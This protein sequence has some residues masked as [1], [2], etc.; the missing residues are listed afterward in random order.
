M[1]PAMFMLLWL[2][3]VGQ[4][5]WAATYYVRPAG[6]GTCATATTDNDAS[7]VGSIQAGV[8]CVQGA[9]DTVIVHGGTYSSFSTITV[10]PNKAGTSF[11]NPITLKAAP[12]ESVTLQGELD[13]LCAPCYWIIERISIDAGD[14]QEL[15]T[16]SGDFVRWVDGEF[17]NARHSGMQGCGG[18]GCEFIRMKVHHNGTGPNTKC[19]PPNSG[20]QCHGIYI[21]DG[22]GHL[23]DGGEFYNNEAFGIHGHGT[24]SQITIRNIKAHNNG[25]GGIF[26]DGTGP[27]T[28]YNNVLYNDAGGMNI[29]A[30]AN[31]YSNTAYGNANDGFLL[32]KTGNTIRNNIAYN[33]GANFSTQGGNTFSNNLCNATGGE[34]TLAGN[35]GFVNAPGGDFHLTAGS[36]AID[37]GFTLGAPYNVDADGV[38]RPQGAAYDIGAYEF[39]AAPPPQPDP[40][41]LVGWWKANGDA[42]DSS[43][44]GRHAV[45]TGGATAT[46][47][48]LVNDGGSSFTL[49]GVNAEITVTSTGIGNTTLRPSNLG[50]SLWMQASS[51]PGG[52][53]RAVVM[54]T[55]AVGFG[56]AV[57]WGADGLA[58]FW[59]NN[60]STAAMATGTVLNNAIHHLAASYD[61]AVMRLWVDN[62]QVASFA[63]T[64]VIGYS[65]SETLYIGGSAGVRCSGLIDQVRIYDTPLT[66]TAVAN[67]FAEGPAVPQSSFSVTH[68][69][70]AR[71]NLAEGNWLTATDASTS[72]FL[73]MPVGW[74][75]AIHYVGAP[76]TPASECFPLFCRVFHAGAWGA[77]TQV[78][79]T[80]GALGIRYHSDTAVAQGAATTALLPLD[81]FTPIAGAFLA[82]P[83]TATSCRVS[84]TDVR[85]SE[86]EARIAFGAPLVAGDQVQCRPHRESGADF[87]ADK[88]VTQITVTLLQPPSAGRRFGGQHLGGHAR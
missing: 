14:T 61:G 30:T 18:G 8:N 79:D 42:T 57:G 49:D 71:A 63:T 73:D 84:M 76:P 35:P 34:C 52:V 24:F 74:R 83:F 5:A 77:W 25:L 17:K 12:G 36:P 6:T 7:A 33:N 9:G 62:A 56:Y 69:R 47:A 22:S 2:V 78:G 32:W 26:L 54:G 66:A 11:A 45:M 40:A 87:G 75:S 19:I 58:F 86:F 43:G 15:A 39:G 23:I 70:L 64:E 3:A 20:G 13:F 68:Q 80:L 65:G 27:H 53:C 37:Q 4:T 88:Y 81:S 55:G 82:A 44:F 38:S 29:N 21:S 59:I 41:G 16:A 28:L 50:I 60:G 51:V 67:L 85:H 46:G 72:V 10:I 1:R 31:I 48:P